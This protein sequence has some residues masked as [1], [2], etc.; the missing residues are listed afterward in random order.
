[1]E[2]PVY[3]AQLQFIY[4]YINCSWADTGWQQTEHTSVHNNKKKKWEVRAVPRLCELYP[5][6]F[7]T[8][9]E[10]AQ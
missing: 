8:T 3:T 7:L 6:I 10:K 2:R 4:I 5:C 9:D 1:M